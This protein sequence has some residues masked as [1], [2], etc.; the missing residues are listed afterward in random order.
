MEPFQETDSGIFVVC[1]KVHDMSHD[2]SRLLLK[3]TVAR[4]CGR[5]KATVFWTFIR[6]LRV[7]MKAPKL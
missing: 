4:E 5:R 6:T 7:C 3:G 2:E 1:E